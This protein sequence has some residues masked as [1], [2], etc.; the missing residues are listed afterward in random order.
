[1][2]NDFSIEKNYGNYFFNKMKDYQKQKMLFIKY[3]DM[4]KDCI[5]CKGKDF[6]YD[7]VWKENDLRK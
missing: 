2:M 5:K 3:I 7:S 4:I 6:P 1:M